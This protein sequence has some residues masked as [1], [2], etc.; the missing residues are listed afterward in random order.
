LA[1]YQSFEKVRD[2]IKKTLEEKEQARLKKRWLKR[3]KQ[4]NYVIIFD[5]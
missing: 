2:G 1:H 4:K 3:L 5:L